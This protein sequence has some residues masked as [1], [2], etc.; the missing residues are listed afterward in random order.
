MLYFWPILFE[1]SQ[2]IISFTEHDLI[3][4]NIPVTKTGFIIPQSLQGI[5]DEVVPAQEH[6]FLVQ[7]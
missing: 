6:N 7:I 1:L 5:S 4:F 2:S 3:T